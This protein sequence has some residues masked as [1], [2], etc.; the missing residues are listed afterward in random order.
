MATTSTTNMSSSSS[1][2]ELQHI[3]VRPMAR[4]AG[5][6]APYLVA[7]AAIH[8]RDQL[9]R[10]YYYQ[11][12]KDHCGCPPIVLLRDDQAADG[13][14]GRDEKV[15]WLRS[16]Q[17]EHATLCH[18]L[19]PRPADFCALALYEASP[20]FV[21]L[22]LYCHTA[23]LRIVLADN[24]ND[25]HV[26]D[27]DQF[28]ANIAKLG[29]RDYEGRPIWSDYA[30][31]LTKTKKKPVDRKEVEQQEEEEVVEQE[32]VLF[33]SMTCQRSDHLHDKIADLVERLGLNAIVT[34]YSMIDRHQFMASAATDNGTAAGNNNI[35][36]WTLQELVGENLY[37][38]TE[39]S[40]CAV[41]IEVGLATPSPNRLANAIFLRELNQKSRAS[42]ETNGAHLDY[43]IVP[44]DHC[45]I[46]AFFSAGHHHGFDVDHI[47]DLVRLGDNFVVL[48]I[49]MGFKDQIR[50]L[51][52]H[53]FMGQGETINLQDFL[54]KGPVE[55]SMALH[56]I[57]VAEFR[58][59]LTLSQRPAEQ[60]VAL[61]A[62]TIVFSDISPR[63]IYC[64]QTQE[65]ARSNV[66]Q[67]G[68]YW[69]NSML[70]WTDEQLGINREVRT[71]L[72]A[73]LR[74][75]EQVFASAGLCFNWRPNVDMFE[76]STLSFPAHNSSEPRSPFRV[77]V[78]EI[79]NEVFQTM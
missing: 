21:D 7:T 77:E 42:R 4:G 69:R 44:N 57:F 74:L 23:H 63:W 14:R 62:L 24:D 12:W 70:S 66:T 10:Q 49:G 27:H 20:P 51:R 5:P 6:H 28:A 50:R 40:Q 1:R 73:A 76:P 67:L 33:A 32:V 55:S 64:E 11:Q 18:W 30:T 35:S 29:R 9:Q 26:V 36:W 61:L 38:D 16:V 19:V 22:E 65:E 53:F 75:R 60:L 41:P 45:A 34:G 31:W 13:R 37:H 52:S 78:N 54:K 15:T 48:W 43:M 68:D 25:K 3:A 17:A 72:C 2:D 39:T 8:A 79:V 46:P 59:V 47:M 56:M 58:F 71:A